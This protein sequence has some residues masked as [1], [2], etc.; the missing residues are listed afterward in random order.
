MLTTWKESYGQHRQHIQIGDITLSAK[1]CLVKGMV[2]PVV[3]YGCESWTLKKAGH[4][5]IDAFEQWYWKRLLRV[6]WPTRRFNQSILNKMSTECS[7]EGLMLKLKLWYFVHLMGRADSLKRPWCW[8][9]FMAGG[10]GYERGWDVDGITDSMDVSL[11]KLWELLMDREAWCA[12]VHGL[13]KSRTWL[14]LLIELN[15]AH[16]SFFSAPPPLL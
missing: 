1:I 11:G 15:W 9:R 13:A 2:F 12:V 8:E 16:T 3:M 10:E 14:S 4:R 7:L 5:R 6:P